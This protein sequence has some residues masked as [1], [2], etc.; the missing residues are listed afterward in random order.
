MIVLHCAWLT[1]VG[2]LV[3]WAED[4]GRPRT[5]SPRRGRPPRRPGQR[6]HPFALDAD[7]IRVA[8]TQHGGQGVEGLIEVGGLEF[9]LLLPEAAGGPFA[10]PWLEDGADDS[11]SELPV[12]SERL[13]EWTV[14]GVLLDW[15][16]ACHVP[17]RL[18]AVRS[19]RLPWPSLRAPDHSAG[20]SPM[21]SASPQD[22]ETRCSPGA[23]MP[24]LRPSRPD[25][26]S[27]SP[28]IWSYANSTLLRLPRMQSESLRGSARSTT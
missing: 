20:Q 21:P 14:P 3:V 13:A 6:P 12:L 19:N 2:R 1:S 5:V 26:G 7:R 16:G 28:P 15:P 18:V 4:G 27:L 22:E 10:S 23:L 24:T 9:L 8:M 17:S 25:P 11:M